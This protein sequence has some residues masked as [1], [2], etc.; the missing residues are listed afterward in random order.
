MLG[1]DAFGENSLL[2]EP[3][4]RRDV[5]LQVTFHVVLA[6]EDLASFGLENDQALSA[7]TPAAADSVQDYAGLARRLGEL[8]TGANNNLCAVRLE[9]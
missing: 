3:G 4:F 6:G 7:R 8:C 5:Y 9:S 2:E 1:V